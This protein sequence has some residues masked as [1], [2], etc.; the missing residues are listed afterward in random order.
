MVIVGRTCDSDT[1]W[2]DKEIKYMDPNKYVQCSMEC[3][4]IMI[5][6]QENGSV[7]MRMASQLDPKM[8]VPGVVLN[9]FVEKIL[10]TLLYVFDK[11]A[12]KLGKENCPE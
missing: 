9:I 3:F 10:Q 5:D 11:K 6:Q 4:F 7:V 8:N 2:L 12:A 1:T